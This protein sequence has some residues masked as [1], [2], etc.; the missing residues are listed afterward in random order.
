[1]VNVLT[2]I[3]LAE[4]ML[5]EIKHRPTK[6]S[7]AIEYYRLI[8]KQHEVEPEAFNESMDVYFS[9]PISLDSLYTA[10]IANIAKIKKK[11]LIKNN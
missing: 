3:H 11:D 4:S 10:V 9:D 1:M 7:L 8:F 5:S 2:D 6:D